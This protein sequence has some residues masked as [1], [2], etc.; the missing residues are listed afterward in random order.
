MLRKRCGSE[1]RGRGAFVVLS[2]LVMATLGSVPVLGELGLP[3]ALDLAL[4]TRTQSAPDPGLENAVRTALARGVDE[5]L[6]R[7]LLEKGTPDVLPS[8]TLTAWVEHAGQLAELGLP[9]NPVVSRYLQGLAKGVPISRIE[10]AVLVLEDRLRQ[11][12]LLVDALGAPVSALPSARLITIDHVAYALGLG[13]PVEEVERSL[14]LAGTEP[15]PARAAQA[16][17]LTLGILTASGLSHE[18]SF[19]LVATAWDK[20]YRGDSMERLG[21]AL[22]TANPEGGAPSQK[23]VQEVLMLLGEESSQDRFFEGLDELMGRQGYR[24]PVI[25]IEGDANGRRGD[26]GRIKDPIVTPKDQDNQRPEIGN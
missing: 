22:G 14:A 20:G 24:L 8:E 23:L 12:A 17:V 16:P 21:K 2:I 4:Q 19:E 3:A 10:S 5:A 9:V 6:L 15:D 7:S 13:L 1:P 26:R 11:A 18:T 25:G